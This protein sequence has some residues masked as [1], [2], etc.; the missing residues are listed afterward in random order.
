MELG[1]CGV[2]HS[3]GH[4]CLIYVSG[5]VTPSLNTCLQVDVVRHMIRAS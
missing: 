3:F 4:T 2:P 5:V 1:P